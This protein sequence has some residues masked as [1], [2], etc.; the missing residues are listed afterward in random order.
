MGLMELRPLAFTLPT[1]P[2]NPTKILW[3]PA[4][5]EEW[6]AYRQQ[7]VALEEATRKKGPTAG[8]LEKAKMASEFALSRIVGVRAFEI[9]GDNGQPLELVWPA[10]KARII[11]KLNQWVG[12]FALFVRVVHNAHHLPHEQAMNEIYGQALEDGPGN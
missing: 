7:C 6:D 3:T 9:L 2:E 12:P 8:A 4:R 11:D 10:D 5:P 1:D